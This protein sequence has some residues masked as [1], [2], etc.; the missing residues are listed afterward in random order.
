[1]D[2]FEPI[3]APR[4]GIEPAFTYSDRWLTASRLNQYQPPRN[5]KISGAYGDRTHDLFHAMEALSQKTELRPLNFLN[6]M[7][8]NVERFAIMNDFG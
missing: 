5:E 2:I 1:M 8:L 7:T 3:L 4:A 6:V